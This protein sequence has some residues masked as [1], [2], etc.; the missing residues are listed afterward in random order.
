MR[1]N[2]SASVVVLE[3]ES[4][5]ATHQT[6]HNS[7]VIHAGIY[8]RP[9]SLKAAVCRR[10]VEALLR[11]C[12]ER[13]IR[14]ELPGKL[15]VAV[16]EDERERLEALL[17][18]GIANGVPGL[19][20]VSAEEMREI[21]PHVRG[22]AG[23]LSPTTG[24][25]S[26]RAVAEALAE[27]LTSSGVE[28]RTGAA[29]L[30]ARATGEGFR[31]VT[32]SEEVV[33]RSVV[34]CC[35]LQADRAARLFGVSPT[36]IVVPFRGEYYRLKPERRGLVRGLVYPVPDPRIPF[37]GVHFTT[38][39]DGEVEAGPNAVLAFAREGYH[40]TDLA[41]RDAI[42]M[43]R[44]SG[45]RRM[46]MRF[47]RVGLEEQY[48]SW[49]KRAFVRSLQRLVPEIEEADLETGRAGVRAMALDADGTLVDDFRIV[50]DDT[51]SSGTAVHVLSAP[52]PAAT[53][54]F[55]IA[56]RVVASL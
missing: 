49:S 30:E 42:E 55:E 43:A 20:A 40:R 35:G 54:A 46:A 23:I 11:Y 3:K 48:R 19:R 15:I 17:E 4:R 56:E 26:F 5:V 37:L 27:E 38:R 29:L 34:T 41:L 14:Y 31:L 21:E 39:I 50:H 10:G 25:V 53:A 24:I 1:R 2:A 16:A 13:G 8:Y 22:V 9:G 47:W 18:R 12:D 45:F 32:S 51:R 6:A 28:I 36:L 52:S 33:A 7:G 44:H